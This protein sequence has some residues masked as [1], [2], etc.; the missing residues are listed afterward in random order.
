MVL[1]ITFS[2]FYA[3]PV[4]GTEIS[5]PEE[6]I[7]EVP[8][9]SIILRTIEVYLDG[10]IAPL[11]YAAFINTSERSVIS[12]SD[13]SLIFGAQIEVIDTRLLLRKGSQEFILEEGDYWHLPPAQ[14]QKEDLNL[15]LDEFYL[16]MRFV[17]EQLGYKIS[18]NSRMG[19]IIL[20]SPDYQGSDPEFVTLEPPQL[21]ANLPRWGTLATTPVMVELW[22]TENIIAGYYTSIATSPAPR[23]RNILLSCNKLNGT[24]VNPGELCSFNQTVGQRTAQAGYQPAGVIVGKRLVS[25]IGGGVC[26]TSSTLYNSLLESQL[27]IVERHPHT[28]RIGYVPENRDATVSWGGADLKFRNNKIYPI[29]ILAQVYETYVIFAIAKVE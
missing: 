21:P 27:Q 13:C 15:Q 7:K 29:K 6:I 2:I 19:A 11:N 14:I 4:I 8:I 10:Q 23:N 12:L 16:P 24:I 18:Y 20:R 5:E 22:P 17:A 28:L 26:Q 3:T 25:G 9:T 1:L